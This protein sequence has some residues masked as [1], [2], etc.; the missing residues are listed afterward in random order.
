MVLDDDYSGTSLTGVDE[1][2]KHPLT[3]RVVLCPPGAGLTIAR[4][5]C[6]VAKPMFEQTFPDPTGGTLPHQ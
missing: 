6:S 1:D 4:T 2:R 5:L 3:D